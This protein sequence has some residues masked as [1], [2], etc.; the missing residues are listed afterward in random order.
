[1]YAPCV[2]LVADVLTLYVYAV[3]DVLQI[4]ILLIIVHVDAVDPL[5]A[6][7]VAAVAVVVPNRLY[8]S[9]I[10]CPH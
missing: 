10:L 2:P 8:T 3:L 7:L 6:R 4:T 9:A 1:M 5:S